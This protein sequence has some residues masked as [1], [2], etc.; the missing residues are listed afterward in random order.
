MQ[1]LWP[2]L[3][4]KEVG[5]IGKI[6]CL[7][8]NYPVWKFNGVTLWNSSIIYMYSKGKY[9]TI[10]IIVLS[11]DKE[12]IYECNGRNRNLTFKAESRLIVIGKIVNLFNLHFQ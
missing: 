8:E 3:Q 7:S 6:M 9:H 2:Y 12:G 4:F 5:N 1:R 11:K 10:E